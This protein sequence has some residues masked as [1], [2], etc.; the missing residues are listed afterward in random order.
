MFFKVADMY[1]LID[2][3]AKA[4][5][6]KDSTGN[7]S[8]YITNVQP[9][10]DQGFSLSVIKSAAKKLGFSM[11]QNDSKLRLHSTNLNEDLADLLGLISETA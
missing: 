10:I 4:A 7:H 8:V 5:K 9:L 1:H 3:L 11:V 6:R 2:N